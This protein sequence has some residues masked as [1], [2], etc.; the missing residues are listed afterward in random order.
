VAQIREAWPELK[1]VLRGDSG[2][3]RNEL[4][5]WCENNG[6]DFVFSLA[7]N[8]RLRRIIGQQM[9]EATQQWNRTGKPA[10]VFT[11]SITGQ[12][13][14]RRAAGSGNVAWWPRPSTSMGKRIHDLW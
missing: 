8:Q 10:R 1:V 4:M 14:R 6:V 13:R 12:R 11:E 9:H 2:F 7:R 5:S 3:C